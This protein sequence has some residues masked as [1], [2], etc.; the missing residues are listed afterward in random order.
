MEQRPDLEVLS[1]FRRSQ[2]QCS[3][4]SDSEG[5][6]RKDHTT[7]KSNDGRITGSCKSFSSLD[8][9]E[10]QTQLSMVCIK[11]FFSYKETISTSCYDLIWI[12]NYGG[13]FFRSASLCRFFLSVSGVLH[14]LT[15][16]ELLWLIRTCRICGK[17]WMQATSCPIAQE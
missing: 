7:Q 9:T 14:R 8:E 4:V 10:L 15:P 5:L 11:M 13:W 17:G 12:D 1:A 3:A 2:D 16:R 6:S